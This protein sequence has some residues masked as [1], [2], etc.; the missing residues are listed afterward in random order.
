MVNNEKIGVGIVTCNRPGSFKA[1][2]ASVIQNLDVD[3][4]IVVKNKDN[5]YGEIDYKSA[6]FFS[7]INDVGV[8][9]CK[10]I[11]LS[12]LMDLDCQHIFVIED[13]VEIVD[14]SVFRKHIETAQHFKLGHLNWNTVQGIASNKTYTINDDGYSLD[15]STRLCGCFS[16]FSREALEQC[17]LIDAKHYINALDHVEHFYRI[18]AQDFTT[19]YLAFAGIHNGELLL[20]NIGEGHSTIDHNTELYQQR[21]ISAYQH[22]EQT[23]GRKLNQFHAPTAQEVLK[24]LKDRMMFS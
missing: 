16:Y 21:L 7:V 22:F 9:K 11:I 12:K 2:F 18:A 10:N 23:Y 19:P 14:S 24:F 5:D 3:E 13:D 1:L 4:T 15:I 20:K 6:Y 17:G 8:G